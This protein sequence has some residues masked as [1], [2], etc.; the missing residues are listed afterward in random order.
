MDDISIEARELVENFEKLWRAERKPAEVDAVLAW[1]EQQHPQMDDRS[2]R[3]L[4]TRLISLD[5]EYRWRN[6]ATGGREPTRRLEDY[7][8]AF[9]KLGSTWPDELVAAE[10]RARRTWGDR[11]EHGPFLERFPRPHD[12]L[13]ALLERIDGKAPTGAPGAEPGTPPPEFPALDGFE[14]IEC[15]GRG[16]MGIVYKARQATLGRLVAIKMILADRAG[17]LA[18]ERFLVEARAVSRLEHP[19]I[20]RLYEIHEEVRSPFFALEFCPGG[21]L[22]KLIRQEPLDP[23]RAAEVVQQLAEA[24][25]FAHE[26]GILHRDLKPANVLLDDAGVPKVA[27]FGLAKLA[28]D[29]A[30][31]TQTGQILGTPNY[32]APE[33]AGGAKGQVGASA[34][35]YSLG[36]TLYALLTASPPFVGSSQLDILDL[37]RTREPVPPSRL[38]AKVPVDLETIC[39]K[40]LR[41]EPSRRYA[42]A[43]KLAADLDRFLTGRPIQARPVGPR[44]RL[45]LWCR[46][47]PRIAGLAGT[48]ALLLVAVTI[49]SVTFGITNARDRD[50]IAGTNQTLN[51]ANARLTQMNV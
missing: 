7:P 30:D 25:H 29:D 4:I 31:R 27:D 34:D 41:K 10:Y 13:K 6:A 26:R 40:C 5:L 33:Q 51:T 17:P 16:G 19:N 9:A 24:V 20:V 37:V 36:A 35:I 15:L 8:R 44:E 12:S 32:M 1:S 48:V 50:T 43:G 38:A 28:E 23:R 18:I 47:N 21:S 39:L 42:D 11:P 49:V 46:R 14:V 45:T 3:W 22:D 2:R